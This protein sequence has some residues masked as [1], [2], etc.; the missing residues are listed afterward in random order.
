[1]GIRWLRTDAFPNWRSAQD[2]LNKPFD[3]TRCDALMKIAEDNHM[4]I[5]SNFY[6]PPQETVSPE[7][8]KAYNV[9]DH[10]PEH[11][12]QFGKWAYE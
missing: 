12:E 9:A 8:N 1:M 6:G 4:R 2:K 5:L 10:G 3:W 7:R 11:D